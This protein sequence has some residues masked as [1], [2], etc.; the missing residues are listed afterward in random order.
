M[1]SSDYVWAKILSY[2]E[3]LLGAITVSAWFDDAKVVE[4]TEEQLIIYSPS[5][6]RRDVIRNRAA[7]PIR[8][9]LKEIF[10]SDAKLVVFDEEELDA[11]RNKDKKNVT[12][13]KIVV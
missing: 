13:R 9:A 8:D 3:D 10:Q 11:F 12:D 6:F 7:G 4:L 5:D 2:L 1:Y